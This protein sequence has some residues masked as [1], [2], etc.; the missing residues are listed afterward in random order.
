MVSWFKNV[1]VGI[2]SFLNFYDI[3]NTNGNGTSISTSTRILTSTPDQ[4]PEYSAAS[5]FDLNQ[6][7]QTG[8]LTHLPYRQYSLNEI[9]NTTTVT[10]AITVPISIPSNTTKSQKQSDSEDYS[11][12]TTQLITDDY[13]TQQK[14]FDPEN[15]SENP[16]ILDSN[17]NKTSQKQSDLESVSETAIK[18]ETDDNTTFQK[19]SDLENVSEPPIPKIFSNSLYPIT[20]I[21]SEIKVENSIFNFP[22]LIS[23]LI[24]INNSNYTDILKL[25]G[26]NAKIEKK[27]HNQNNNVNELEHVV[28]PAV[29]VNQHECKTTNN[30]NEEQIISKFN[31]VYIADQ[32]LKKIRKVLEKDVKDKENLRLNIEKL[33][34]LCFSELKSCCTSSLLIIQDEKMIAFLSNEIYIFNININDMDYK[35][36]NDTIMTCRDPVDG[37][38]T[39]HYNNCCQIERERAFA[40]QL[41]NNV[42]NLAKL[43]N[44][45]DSCYKNLNYKKSIYTYFIDINSDE[46]K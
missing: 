5:I 38:S 37:L 7:K 31:D 25:L 11:D 33:V 1:L 41:F 20:I 40:N 36:I 45:T 27:I 8:N 46:M 15:N 17:D 6:N 4:T 14:Q 34:R 32:S 23:N 18:L 24:M 28:N 39:K 44:D 26:F 9:D 35:N 42:F 21:K 22:N 30:I 16:L 13:N 19:Q 2:L 12:T 3:N 10:E 43:N 29:E